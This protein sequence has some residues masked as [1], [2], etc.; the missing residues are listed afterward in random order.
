MK[1][2]YWFKEGSRGTWIITSAIRVVR[3]LDEKERQSILK[4]NGYDEVA[5]YARYK[6]A[7]EKRMAS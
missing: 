2:F 1:G 7:F 5:A 4:K 3:V 6:V